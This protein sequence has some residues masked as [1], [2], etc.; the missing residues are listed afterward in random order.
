MLSCFC[1]EAV[2]RLFWGCLQAVTRPFW[3]C[4][5]AVKKH[6]RIVQDYCITS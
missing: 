3:C 2:T 4:P 5:E 6:H 1:L